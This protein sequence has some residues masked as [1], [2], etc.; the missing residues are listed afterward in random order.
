MKLAI[1]GSR[2]FS[3]YEKLKT[4]VDFFSVIKDLEITEIVSGGAKGAD[5]LAEQ[6][7]KDHDLLL[8]VF[9]ANWDLHGK[10][11]GYIRNLDIVHYADAIIAFWDG[12][13]RGTLHTINLSKQYKKILHIVYF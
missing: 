12:Q 9:P 2:S 5:T 11:A 13:S 6:Y 8:K 7:A 1:V 3:D 10:S 4:E